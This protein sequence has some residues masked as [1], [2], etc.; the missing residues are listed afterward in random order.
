[1]HDTYTK[2]YTRNIILKIY[3]FNFPIYINDLYCW[4]YSSYILHKKSSKILQEPDWP[5]VSLWNLKSLCFICSHSF[6]FV[7]PLPAI[8]CHSLSLVINC[9]HSL[10]LVVTPCHSFFT[11]FIALCHSLS[12]VVP[13]LVIHCR[14]MYHSPVFLWM[15][16]LNP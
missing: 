13:L 9:C 1:M 6:S 10:L 11:R 3:I 5:F 15:I 7:V 14:S 16:L 4:I 8:R 12:R 2:Y